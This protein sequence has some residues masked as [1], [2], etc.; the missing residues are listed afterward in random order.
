MAKRAHSSGPEQPLLLDE[1]AVVMQCLCD[2]L[3]RANNETG[4]RALHALLHCNQVSSRIVQP[5]FCKSV[6]T[7]Y[8]RHV[9]KHA[10]DGCR[11]IEC[12]DC[13]T[14]CHQCQ[15]RVCGSC[16]K[17][18][19]WA[20]CMFCVAVLYCADCQ[21]KRRCPYT[22]DLWCGCESADSAAEYSD[23]ASSIVEDY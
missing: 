3:I 9:V 7:F 16:R 2:S 14:Q 1:V 10:C 23:D 6:H 13:Q 8:G 22:R 15:R 11:G 18:E 19:G 12:R 5:A 4:Y 17:R 20:F 21:E